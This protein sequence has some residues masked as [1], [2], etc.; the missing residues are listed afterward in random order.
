VRDH[1]GASIEV[2][3]WELPAINLGDF[4]N[5]IPAPLGLG[6]VQLADGSN[7]PGFLCE[8]YAVNNAQ[9]LTACGGW[10]KFLTSWD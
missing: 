7:V 3:V 4:L 5:Q 8:A 10:R 9:E 1:D 6:R 2:E